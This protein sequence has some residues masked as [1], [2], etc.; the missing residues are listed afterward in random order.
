M[1][2]EQRDGII[3]VVFRCKILEFSMLGNLFPS[4]GY[5]AGADVHTALIKPI[6][7]A[8]AFDGIANAIEDS[9]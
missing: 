1:K 8:A 4:G 5:A 6:G 7:F 3:I 9:I 2:S